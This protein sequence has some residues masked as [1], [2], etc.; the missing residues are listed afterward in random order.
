MSL[1]NEG[2]YLR[3]LLFCN[4][5]KKRVYQEIKYDYKS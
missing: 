1:I 4:L 3:E 2:F 5:I